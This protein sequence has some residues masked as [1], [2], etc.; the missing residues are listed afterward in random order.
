MWLKSL[1]N[2]FHSMDA[3]LKSHFNTVCD[4]LLDLFTETVKNL[5]SIYLKTA[6]II[7]FHTM[8]KYPYGL[9]IYNLPPEFP[10][11]YFTNY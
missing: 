9:W 4:C 2:G 10:A 7:V 11:I 1:L 3:K 6:A 5:G 8:V